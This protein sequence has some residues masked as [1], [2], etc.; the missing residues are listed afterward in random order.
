MPDSCASPA[1]SAPSSNALPSR[2][3]NKQR[4]NTMSAE[5]MMQQKAKSKPKSD[6]SLLQR[7]IFFFRTNSPMEIWVAF[8][9]W[10]ARH[11]YI[12][13]LIAVIFIAIGMLVSR[14]ISV[15][16]SIVLI[17]FGALLSKEDYDTAGYCCYAA[18]FMDF[19]IPYII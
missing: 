10:I 15:A 1:N 4:R 5:A 7:I 2:K 8:L 18:A 17:F 14:Y 6:A 13:F 12:V 11:P 9:S 3:Q 19:I 16:G